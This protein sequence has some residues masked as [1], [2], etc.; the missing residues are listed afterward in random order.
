MLHPC[1]PSRPPSP[2]GSSFGSTRKTPCTIEGQT[3]PGPQCTAVVRC[4]E[5]YYT[6]DICTGGLVWDNANGACDQPAKVPRCAEVVLMPESEGSRQ[7]P[8]TQIFAN[9]NVHSLSPDLPAARLCFTTHKLFLVQLV[10]FYLLFAIS[11]SAFLPSSSC[12]EIKYLRKYL[13]S[14]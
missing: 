2:S 10:A 1:Q 3:F 6:T 11:L 7:F 4:S 9:P 13:H 8:Q 12:C 5:G 14:I